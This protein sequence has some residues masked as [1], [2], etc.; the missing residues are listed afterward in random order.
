[1][2]QIV[3]GPITTF[4]QGRIQR[5]FTTGQLVWDPKSSSQINKK[6]K[7]LSNFEWILP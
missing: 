2:M 1:M 3:D 4:N 5:G 7:I 6:I